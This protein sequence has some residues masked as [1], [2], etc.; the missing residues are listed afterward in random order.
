M[1]VMKANKFH[2]NM[3]MP[4]C[5]PPTKKFPD[6]DRQATA[7]G[8]GIT[9]SGLPEMSPFHKDFYAGFQ[10]SHW[11]RAPECQ[12]FQALKGSF[13]GEGKNDFSLL[14]HFIRRYTIESKTN[15]PSS[16]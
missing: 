8:M 2:S 4:I 5:L 14:L 9:S 6:T 1:S 3:I 7:V 16:K 15:R 13:I 11:S 10:H 12:I